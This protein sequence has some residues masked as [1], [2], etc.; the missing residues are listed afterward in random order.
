M[1]IEKNAA[2]KAEQKHEQQQAAA[3]IETPAKGVRVLSLQI[4]DEDLGGDPYNRTG[5]FCLLDI[6]ER[7]R[8]SD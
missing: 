2:W 4:E 6:K 8:S 3:E 1:S 7:E 5:H